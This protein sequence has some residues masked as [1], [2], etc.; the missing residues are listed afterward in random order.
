MDHINYKIKYLKYKSKY[1]E[2]KEMI[3][4]NPR[5]IEVEVKLMNDSGKFKKVN[6]LKEENNIN[7]TLKDDRELEIKL[8]SKFPFV[9]PKIIH[10]GKYILESMLDWKL[11]KKIHELLDEFD[12]YPLFPLDNISQVSYDIFLKNG[13]T[14]TSFIDIHLIGNMLDNSDILRIDLKSGEIYNGATLLNAIN[15]YITKVHK[16]F[17]FKIQNRFSSINIDVISD[18]LFENLKNKSVSMIIIIYKINTVNEFIDMLKTHKNISQISKLKPVSTNHSGSEPTYFRINWNLYSDKQKNMIVENMSKFLS[19]KNGYE[20]RF[21][22]NST[23]PNGDGSVN[24]MIYYSEEHLDKLSKLFGFESI[25]KSLERI[26]K[27]ES[28]D[29]IDFIYIAFGDIDITKLQKLEDLSEVGR[30]IYDEY[31]K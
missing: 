31:M 30:R 9:K 2:L 29:K 8:D 11:T 4:G 27:F 28:G 21:K 20:I 13:I 5:R 6:Y 16:N 17:I 10:N 23:T 14:S 22:I 12:N 18:E 15:Y 7:V 3:G 24:S 25:E 1:F 26:T 19:D